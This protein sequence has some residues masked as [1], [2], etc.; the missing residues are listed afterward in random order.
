MTFYL[1]PPRGDIHLEKILDLCRDRC[2]FLSMLDE[3]D[4]AEDKL[5]T[6]D[7]SKIILVKFLKQISP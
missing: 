1:K 3:I 6:S 5:V 2:Q 4:L 7:F